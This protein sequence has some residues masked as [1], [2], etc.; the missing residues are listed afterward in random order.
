MRDRFTFLFVLAIACAAPPAPAL[1]VALPVAPRAATPDVLEIPREP[2]A[3]YAAG[4]TWWL[5]G[6]REDALRAFR[7]VVGT[8][9]VNGDPNPRRRTRIPLTIVMSE[10]GRDKDAGDRTVAITETGVLLGDVRKH[11][12]DRFV[13]LPDAYQADVAAPGLVAITTT[14]EIALVDMT[15]GAI[16]ARL[17]TEN[18]V[19]V[20]RGK[21]RFF[22]YGSAGGFTGE[23]WDAATRARL[24]TFHDSSVQ[25]LMFAGLSEDESA[26]F[27]GGQNVSVWDVAT[28]DEILSYAGAPLVARGPGFSRDGRFVAYGTIDFDHTPRIGTTH[29]FDRRAKRVVA[30]SH[31]SSFPSGFAFAG[32]W[33]AVG[34]LRKGCLLEAP[35]LR[36]VACSAE[37]RPSAGIDDDLQDTMPT[38]VAGDSALALAT[39][40]GSLLIARVPSMM[41][42]WKGR[43]RFEGAH[44]VDSDGSGASWTLGKDGVPVRDPPATENAPEPTIRACVIGSWLFPPLA[45][46][47]PG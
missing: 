20:A 3:A 17:A 26:V 10:V 29:L 46:S 47:T 5:A 6:K 25:T 18:G 33:L 40:D 14:S 43:A 19:V 4:W 31:A 44:L 11:A 13:E 1:H 34:D 21:S 15:S 38:F 22:L 2:G 35:Q 30:T 37:V 16:V 42:I 32:K 36:R 24:R 45:C 23:V 27:A 28:G 41:T 9:L 7:Y 39:S 8:L 12:F